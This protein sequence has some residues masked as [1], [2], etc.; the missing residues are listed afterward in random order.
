MSSIKNRRNNINILLFGYIN[1][2]AMD[3]S[4]VFMSSVTTMLS[5]NPN[6]NIDLVLAN[7][8]RRDLLLQPLYELENVNI[9]CPYDDSDLSEKEFPWKNKNRMSFQEAGEVID[10][11]W[12]K[13]DYDWFII[14]GIEVANKLININPN[15]ISNS[16]VYMTGITDSNQEL[17]KGK[18][19]EFEQ[20]RELNAYI[21]C[22][23]EEMKEFLLTKLDRSLFED[24][25]IPLNPM[26][27]DTVDEFEDIFVK[28]NKYFKLCYTGK[29]HKGW[30][31]IP[32]IVGFKEILEE[33]PEATLEV[34]GDMFKPDKDNPHYVN[35]LKYLLNSTRNLTWYGALSREEARQ[36]ILSS[37]IGFTWRDPSMDTSLELSTKLLEYGTLGKAVV[38]NPTPMH[39]KIFGDDYPLYA[40]T[41]DDYVRVVKE[42]MI[43]PDI[44]EEAARKMFEGSK[45]FTF[46]QILN[47]LLPYLVKDKVI[48]FLKSKNIDISK[49]EFQQVLNSLKNEKYI[50]YDIDLEQKLVITKLNTPK[51]LIELLEDISKHGEIIEVK[52]IG[53]IIFISVDVNSNGFY[54]NFYKNFKLD[55]IKNTIFDMRNS[56]TQFKKE[57]KTQSFRTIQPQNINNN[58]QSNDLAKNNREYMILQSKYN[59]LA[60]SKLGKIQLSYWR[61]KRKK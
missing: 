6:I 59:A 19:N 12:R 57:I 30:N 1:M 23:T 50:K 3:G 58:Q 52:Q 18:M 13:N 40:E 60:N 55:D 42:A 48:E 36:L 61:R 33:I 51:S 21:L 49:A 4:A 32:M 9:I 53:D 46:T 26:V 24:K 44:Y 34:A 28:K 14:R 54:E 38:L 37:D 41:L 20:L 15:I 5:K 25:I 8:I 45:K 16:M 29:F 27:P 17:T 56:N 10:Y 7:P 47:N 39:K 11:Y 35:D 43:N 31:S 22:Q 2:N